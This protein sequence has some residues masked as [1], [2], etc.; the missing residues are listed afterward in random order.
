MQVALWQAVGS[1]TKNF[2][3]N[4]YHTIKR[5]LARLIANLFDA[6]LLNRIQFYSL[7]ENV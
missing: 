5:T 1:F 3:I 4:D 7:V 2:N 6:V